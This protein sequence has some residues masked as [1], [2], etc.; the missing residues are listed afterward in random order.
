MYFLLLVRLSNFCY[1][2]LYF[3]F[4]EFPIHIICS[5]SMGTLAFLFCLWAFYIFRLLFL[6]CICNIHWSTLLFAI[7]FCLWSF[8]TNRCFKFSNSL[9]YCYSLY[10]FHYFY[11][12]L[13]HITV[14]NFS[15]KN[16]IL[17]TMSSLTNAYL[18]SLHSYNYFLG[19]FI[20]C[21]K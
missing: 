15:Q 16:C 18:E 6:C 11:A 5:F 13:V 8:L 17:T 14:S 12:Y 20:Y 19:L 10:F 2:H 4:C 7:C 9:I 1:Y 3:F 21:F